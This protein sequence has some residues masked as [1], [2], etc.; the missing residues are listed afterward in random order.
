MALTLSL[1]SIEMSSLLVPPGIDLCQMRRLT[2]VNLFDDNQKSTA[3]NS[4]VIPIVCAHSG[5]YLTLQC[6]KGN[7]SLHKGNRYVF[8]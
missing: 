5:K 7:K 6:Q 1:L 4:F 3:N 2:Q 8:R